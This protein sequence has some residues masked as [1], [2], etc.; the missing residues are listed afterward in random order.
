MTTV[1]DLVRKTRSVRRFRESAEVSMETLEYL[2]D[3][4]RCTASAANKQP[5]K[6][7]LCSDRETNATVFSRL[8]WAA[9]L[10]DWPGPAAGERPASY[11]VI[12]LD[13]EIS[14][15]VDC[16]HGIA[17][18]T[19]ALG[20]AEIGL[21]C[22]ILGSVQR[23][24]L[25]RDLNIPESMRILLVLALGAPVEECRLELLGPDGSIKY[26]RDR[27]GVHHVPKRGLEEV[28]LRRFG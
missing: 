16:D 11:V 26:Y 20:A 9:C 18:Q 27:K 1:F 13:T 2:V 23:E 24:K 17:A 15:H 12:C 8:A 21:G 28:I 4:A 10:P 25:M 22:C 5:L 3:L 19:M 14:D 6:Y 7:V